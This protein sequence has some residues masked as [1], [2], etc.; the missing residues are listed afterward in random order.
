MAVLDGMVGSG[1][2]RRVFSTMCRADLKPGEYLSDRESEIQRLSRE[3]YEE[4]LKFG[5]AREQARKDLPL[6]TYTEAYWKIDLHNLLHFLRL[7]MDH[8]AQLE[9]R[10]YANV[11]GYNIV[12][13]IFPLVWEAFV[14]YRLKSMQLTYLD[15]LVIQRMNAD[16]CDARAA[17][18]W[19]SDGTTGLREWLEPVCRERDEFLDKAKQL[20]LPSDWRKM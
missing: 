14:D 13:R 11:I 17:V 2:K 16:N 15:Q 5:V 6:S 18:V 19:L 1:E 12:G 8:H 9:I 7:R 3:A 20:G 4:R 10:S